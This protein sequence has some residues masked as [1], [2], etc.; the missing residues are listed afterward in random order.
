MGSKWQ[1]CEA[2]TIALQTICACSNNLKRKGDAFS[3]LSGSCTTGWQQCGTNNVRGLQMLLDD[4][5]LIREDYTGG[6]KAPQG[7]AT[8]DGKFQILRVTNTLLGYAA[9][10]MKIDLLA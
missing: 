4:G 8:H 7:T 3:W 1:N 9:S 5:S 10:K 2:E 6:H